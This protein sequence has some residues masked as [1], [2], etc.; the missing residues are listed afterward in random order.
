[1]MT[2]FATIDLFTLDHV[3]GGQDA[4][5]HGNGNLG[6]TVPVAGANIEVGLQGEYT[7]SN[8]SKC[9]DAVTALPGATPADIRASCGLP[10]GQS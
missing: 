3:H 6:V 8:Y 4:A 7:K 2:A 5:E 10:N 9:V 1:M